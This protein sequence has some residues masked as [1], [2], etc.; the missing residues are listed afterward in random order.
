MWQQSA[1]HTS[2]AGLPQAAQQDNACWRPVDCDLEARWDANAK[3]MQFPVKLQRYPEIFRAAYDPD[4]LAKSPPIDP[5]WQQALEDCFG[6]VAKGEHRIIKLAL[7]P[8]I[9]RWAVWELIRK[10]GHEN[11]WRPVMFFCGE[12]RDGYLPTDLDNE[13]KKREE[14]R[15]F[16]GDHIP[17]NRKDMEEYVGKWSRLR[18]T[19]GQ[20]AKQA[21]EPVKKAFV[22]ANKKQRA[23]EEEV[24]REQYCLDRDSPKYGVRVDRDEDRIHGRTVYWLHTRPDG[25]V[26]FKQKVKIGSPQWD[27]LVT[28]FCRLHGISDLQ[29]LIHRLDTPDPKML[30]KVVVESDTATLRRLFGHLATETRSEH[31]ELERLASERPAEF[32]G[33]R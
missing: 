29:R 15:G 1:N 25:T 9:Q 17:P 10:P 31:V 8:W 11:T 18:T 30:G 6:D 2:F 7:H 4:G 32:F 5:A 33:G 22:E 28:G 12:P 3:C 20:R 21:A 26:R 13:G 16:I 23:F 19:V 27:E 24:L 14:L